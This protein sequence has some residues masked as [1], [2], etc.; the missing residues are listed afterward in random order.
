MHFGNF[1]IPNGNC[2]NTVESVRSGV[3]KPRRSNRIPSLAN[4][5]G[6]S[7][8]IRLLHNRGGTVSMYHEQKRKKGGEAND[9]SHK[10]GIRVRPA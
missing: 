7:L 2:K 8:P 6:S 10:G 9:R 5:H 1:A 4:T 3:L